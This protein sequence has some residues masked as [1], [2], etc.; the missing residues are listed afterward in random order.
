MN[1]KIRPFELLDEKPFEII[2]HFS[3]EPLTF[4]DKAWKR[5]RENSNE[6]GQWLNFSLEEKR[7]WLQVI[8]LRCSATSTD[9]IKQTISI[10]GSL[11]H[12]EE[13]FFICLGE[14]INGP[15]STAVI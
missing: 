7:A 5:L 11:I 10:D 15:F 3:E 2:G 13:T 4:A 6:F 12:D 9:R 14:A 8:R 1:I